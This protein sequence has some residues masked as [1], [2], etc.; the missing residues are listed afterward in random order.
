MVCGFRHFTKYSVIYLILCFKGQ[1]AAKQPLTKNMYLDIFPNLRP[2]D[3]YNLNSSP[4]CWLLERAGPLYWAG[5]A[6]ALYSQQLDQVPDYV[7]E[8]ERADR[9]LYPGEKFDT[10]VLRTDTVE[11]KNAEY[12]AFEQDIAVLNIYFGKD[13]VPGRH[14]HTESIP[15]LL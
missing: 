15:M 5:D 14:G 11:N 3:S 1:C 8:L 9:R 13:S 6:L 7:T 10:E 2:C 12:N 4:L